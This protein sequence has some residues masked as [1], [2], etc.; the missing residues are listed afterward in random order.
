MKQ[1]WRFH[2]EET[3]ARNRRRSRPT[4][5]EERSGPSRAR[6]RRRPDAR[7]RRQAKHQAARRVKML[8]VQEKMVMKNADNSKGKSFTAFRS[9]AEEADTKRENDA[10]KRE[11]QTW[12]RSEERRVG[13]ECRSRWSP[14]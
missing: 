6:V 2:A 1:S 8:D 12:D 11:E 10:M 5:G 14:Y 3:R 4:I 7:R 13:K 9:A